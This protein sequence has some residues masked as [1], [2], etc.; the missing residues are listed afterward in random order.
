[1]VTID[2][3]KEAAAKRVERERIKAAVKE[4][5]L[6]PQGHGDPF[7]TGHNQALDKVLEILKTPPGNCISKA[8]TIS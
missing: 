5:R 2:K 7:E 3:A 6:A 1:M 8:R 4:L